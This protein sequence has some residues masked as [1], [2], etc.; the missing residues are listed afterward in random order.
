MCWKQVDMYHLP[1]IVPDQIHPLMETLSPN[2]SALLMLVMHP[3][4][5]QTWFRNG[6][7]EHNNKFKVL[8]WP[9]KSPD[10]NP[11]QHLWGICWTNKSNP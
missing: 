3:A 8:T 9:P 7:T 5:R 11:I 1:E 10:L 6:L 4:T 2:G